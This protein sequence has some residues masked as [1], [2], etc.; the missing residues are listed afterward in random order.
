MKTQEQKRA[1]AAERQA[2]HDGLSTVE[3]LGKLAVR[4]GASKREKARLL[5]GLTA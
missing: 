1:E 4:R 3:K 5:E 2:V